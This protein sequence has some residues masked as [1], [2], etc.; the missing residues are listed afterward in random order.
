[1][2]AQFESPS[3]NGTLPPKQ[4]A[5][6]T[7]DVIVIG[8]GPGGSTAATLLAQRGRRVLLIEKDHHPRFHIG[9]S[10]LPLNL[11][12]F[13]QLGCSQAIAN[14]GLVKRAMQF[15][16]MEHQVMQKFSF[17]EAWDGT[18]PH[19]YHVRRSEF[20]H[21][22]LQHARASG[23][24]VIEGCRAREFHTGPER[25]VIRARCDDGRTLDLAGS[26]LVDASGRDTFLASRFG[27][28][29]RNQKHTSAALYGHFR[30][31]K[32][33]TGDAEGNIEIFWFAHGWMW[34]IPL[35]DG[36]TS[37]G[38]VC[39]PYYLKTRN[40][41]PSEFFLQTLQSCPPMWERVKDA[42]LIEPATATGNYSYQAD[43]MAGERYVM[44]GDAF[45]FVDPV[46][47]SGVYLAMNSAL[48]AADVVDRALADPA[49][50]PR[51][52]RAF[53]RRV[54]RGLRTFTWMIY[55]MTSPVMR[56]LIMHPR[57]DFGIQRAV[58]S[59]L[60]G[61]VYDS[62]PVRRRMLAFRAIYY[63]SAMLDWRRALRAVFNRRNAVRPQTIYATDGSG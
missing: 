24:Q 34:F 20:D 32:R 46:F 61:D 10:L 31:A 17:A 25:V 35:V 56:N 7:A 62:G 15:H 59:F 1:M 44:V 41:D 54:R 63:F 21:A 47:S 14:V 8:G 52:N 22:L 3:L 51:L 11:P 53:E 13:Q 38:A 5:D 48:F 58:I 12:L 29:R 4:S 40:T 37:V 28:K 50:A 49:A 36:T 2:N 16:S 23:V 43:R 27:I 42:T 30:G 39:W 55:R 60:A 57:D 6:L 33:N 18:P 45:A 9:E 26:Y 19:A